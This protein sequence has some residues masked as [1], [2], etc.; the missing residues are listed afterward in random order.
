MER[1]N[2]RWRGTVRGGGNKSEPEREAISGGE[3]GSEA[4]GSNQRWREVIRLT[5]V[6]RS[7]Q[8]RREAI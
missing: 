4:E 6:E 8:R 7:E 1:S 5:D 2:Q 3:K